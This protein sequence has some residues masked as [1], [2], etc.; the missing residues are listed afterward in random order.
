M[1]SAERLQLTE[2]SD[3]L[4]DAV[5]VVHLRPGEDD[6][7]PLSVGEQQLVHPRAVSS[8]IRDFRMGRTAARLALVMLP[9]GQGELL[10]GSFHCIQP[11][12]Q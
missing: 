11:W 3:A 10:N 7:L 5:T 6:L 2:F 4:G 9:G 8:R 1:P 12:C